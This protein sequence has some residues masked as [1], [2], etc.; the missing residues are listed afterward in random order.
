MIA[1]SGLVRLIT[2]RHNFKSAMRMSTSDPFIITVASCAVATAVTL[3]PLYAAVTEHDVR[4]CCSLANTSKFAA[5]LKKGGVCTLVVQTP[6][7]APF[8]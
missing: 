8:A 4:M 1:I 2:F 3:I 6:E 7:V 5:L